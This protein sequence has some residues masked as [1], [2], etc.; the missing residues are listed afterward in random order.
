[1]AVKTSA[2]DSR[3]SKPRP[4][5][6]I[7]VVLLYGLIST[8]PSAVPLAVPSHPESPS[9]IGHAA[10]PFHRRVPTEGH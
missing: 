2:F 1:M 9:L 3:Q 4:L 5:I 6:G 8:R 7:I 10:Q